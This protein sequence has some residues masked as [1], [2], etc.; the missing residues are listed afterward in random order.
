[1]RRTSSTISSMI[2]TCPPLTHLQ[3]PATLPCS[4]TL[5]T[6]LC[7]HQARSPSTSG[8][9]YSCPVIIS[10][11]CPA[12]FCT[13]DSF[14]SFRSQLRSLHREASFLPYAPHMLEFLKDSTPD[15]LSSLSLSLTLTHTHTHTHTHT[16]G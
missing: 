16:I 9:V 7:V 4:A 12:G 5:A 14:F 6:L 10:T 13:A 2:W 8:C 1:M 3:A 11:L 15:S